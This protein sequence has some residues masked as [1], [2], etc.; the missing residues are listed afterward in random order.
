MKS[1]QDSN[2]HYTYFI[3]ANIHRFAVEFSNISTMINIFF[4]SHLGVLLTKLTS[5]IITTNTIVLLIIVFKEVEVFFILFFF[6]RFRGKRA[7]LRML[8]NPIDSLFFSVK[9]TKE[10]IF[11]A[12]RTLISI[13]N[14]KIFNGI[15]YLIGLSKEKHLIVDV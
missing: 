2:L 12:I 5:H 9:D 8:K 15:L 6:I 11:T 10:S 3:S 14:N 7:H 1:Q 13:S 4:L